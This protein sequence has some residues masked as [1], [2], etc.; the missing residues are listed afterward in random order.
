MT[1][2]KPAQEL[3]R[4]EAYLRLLRAGNFFAGNL[5][6]ALRDGQ[7]YSL[8]NFMGE[9]FTGLVEFVRPLRGFCL[10]AREWNDALL[11]FS[12]EGVPGKIEVQA[13]L[14]TFGVPQ[15]RVDEFAKTWQAQL[16]K[17]HS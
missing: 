2:P 12:I 3:S 10:T 5:H 8:E 7:P 16:T 1:E 9:T 17:I 6:S 13:W 4:E 14:S 11:W 15:S